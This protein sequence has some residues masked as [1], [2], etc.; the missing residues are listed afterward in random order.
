MR[1]SLSTT[2]PV[3]RSPLAESLPEFQHVQ[4][5]SVDAI[6]Y[7]PASNRLYVRFVSGRTYAYYAVRA[8]IYEKFMAADSKGRFFNANIRGVFP[9]QEL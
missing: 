4:S 1:L 3:L 7:D 2:S 5:S 8:S 9:F 6:G